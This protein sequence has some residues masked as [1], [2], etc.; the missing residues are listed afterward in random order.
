MNLLTACD[1]PSLLGF[2]KRHSA[3]QGALLAFFTTL[4]ETPV[5]LDDWYVATFRSNVA[6][7]Y[8]FEL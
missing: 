6:F 2:L 7:E 1:L 5:N 8:C 3:I 4:N